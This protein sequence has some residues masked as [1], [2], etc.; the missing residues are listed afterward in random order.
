MRRTQVLSI[1]VGPKALITIALMMVVAMVVSCSESSDGMSYAD[2]PDVVDVVALGGSNVGGYGFGGED[3]AYPAVYARDLA[4]AA[5]IETRYTAHH[6]LTTMQT[7]HLDA[8]N[9][10]LANDDRIRADLEAA[11]IVILEI[12]IH[13]IL[14]ECGVL[15]VGWTVDCMSE[16]ATAMAA[17]YQ[18]LFAAI[19][20]LVSDDTVVMAF[21]Q[22][23]P[24]P[25]SEHWRDQPDWP[26]MKT[27]G[28]EAWWRG[29]DAAAAEHGAIV[30]DTAHMFLGTEPDEYG[31][32]AEYTQTDNVHLNA[33]GHQLF[34]DLLAANDT[35]EPEP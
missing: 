25:T 1:D 16:T 24:R 10:L 17:G 2:L 35:I 31:L 22:G 4:A 21:N 20:E 8:W 9:E 6:T 34:A 32:S 27:D 23:L 33:E 26:A 15:Y 5:G 29:L 14:L 19:D 7:R 18:D 13:T 12:G 28:F 30:I 11:E 3:V